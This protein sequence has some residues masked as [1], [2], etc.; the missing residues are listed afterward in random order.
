MSDLA[1]WCIGY[2]GTLAVAI[3]AVLVTGWLMRGWP[4]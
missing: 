3:V 4:R 2:F 1:Q